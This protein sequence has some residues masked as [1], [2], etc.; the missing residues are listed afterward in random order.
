MTCVLAFAVDAGHCSTLDTPQHP[1]YRDINLHKD[2]RVGAPVRMHLQASLPRELPAGSRLEASSH[3]RWVNSWTRSIL[4]ELTVTN[5][6]G[7]RH[8]E[9]ASPLEL[10]HAVLH[11]DCLAACNSIL[12]AGSMLILSEPPK[13]S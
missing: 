1:E 2:S 13:A 7:K 3:Q 6:F 9:D 12:A 11:E 8:E 4:H 5:D 10:L